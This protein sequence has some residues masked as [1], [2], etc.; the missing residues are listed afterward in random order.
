MGDT[1]RDVGCAQAH[2]LRTLAVATGRFGM[3][4]L[5]EAGAE[6]VLESLEDT[7]SVLDILTTS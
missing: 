2:G 4:Q 3:D 6:Q 5:R 7:T 1:P